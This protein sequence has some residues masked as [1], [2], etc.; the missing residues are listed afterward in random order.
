[1]AK[2]LI[3]GGADFIGSHL[4]R[5]LVDQ[6]E[7]VRI[8][9][10][11]NSAISNIQ[12]VLDRVDVIYR[13]FMDDGALRHAVQSIDTVYH[14]TSTS[15]PGMALES[16]YYDVL[17][18]LLPTIRLLEL[19]LASGVKKIVYVSSGGTIYGDPQTI[20][21]TEEH[22]LM[23]RSA[24][25]QGKLTIENYL[26]FYARSTSLDISVLRVSNSFG[27]GQSL[28]GEQGL[29]AVAMGCAYYE[30]S[31]KLYGAGKA[32]RDYIYI[33]DVIDAMVL[34]ATQTGSS[35]VNISAAVGHSVMEIVQAVE[36]ISG[37]TIAK[38]FIPDRPSDVQINILDN[39]KAYQLYG[40]T[41]KTAFRDGLAKTWDH[42]MQKESSVGRL[43]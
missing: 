23:P 28:W 6:G 31:L 43:K 9:T 10:R 16:S 34:A 20:P 21:I 13:D 11:P 18:N 33:D 27:P 42:I 26:T 29:I 41:P 1:M 8:L 39:Q 3:L 2:S 22:P 15:S 24:Y 5:R 38:E 36:E 37:R 40:W 17:S 7:I 32:V 4:A 12:D 19:C 30:H 35:I 25:G 14:V